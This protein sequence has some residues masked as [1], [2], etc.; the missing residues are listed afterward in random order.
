MRTEE[1]PNH[2]QCPYRTSNSTLHSF[3]FLMVC[4]VA[5]AL[6]NVRS[7]FV[8]TMVILSHF[9]LD[10]ALFWKWFRGYWVVCFSFPSAQT[11][12]Y[13]LGNVC[14]K[15]WREW[16]LS[17]WSCRRHHRCWHMRCGRH[18]HYRGWS[19][20]VLGNNLVEFGCWGFRRWG[21][22]CWGCFGNRSRFHSRLF[23]FG[24]SR[25]RRSIWCPR[26]GSRCFSSR[27]TSLFLCSLLGTFAQWC[28]SRNV[29][30]PKLMTDNLN[31]LT[32]SAHPTLLVCLG[33]LRAQ[34]RIRSPQ[35]REN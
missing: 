29:I 19:R 21:F 26:S 9:Q 22:R 6:D 35:R 20:W 30:N 25:W 2:N 11:R 34:N 1:P 15:I 32:L 24:Q 7:N 3:P 23:I 17:R 27:N 33:R 10:F 4:P 8:N 5:W 12:R 16:R 13:R 28:G 18:R 31:L 14:R